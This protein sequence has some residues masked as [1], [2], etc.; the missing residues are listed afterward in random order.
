MQ[1]D[2][3]KF[4]KEFKE[5]LYRF[6]LKLIKLIEKLPKDRVCFILGDQLLRSGTSILS[7]YIEGQAASSKKDFIK[8]FEVSLKSIN[9]SKVWI[10]LL[11]DAGKIKKDEVQW[12][13]DELKEFGNIFASS[14]LTLK[15]KKIK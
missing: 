2:K 3:L 8:Y 6:V 4:K 7:N 15:G 13:L 14:I 1:N 9:E 10:A 5:R 11:R 12:F